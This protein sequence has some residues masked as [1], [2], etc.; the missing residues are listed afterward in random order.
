MNNSM[1]PETDFNPEMQSLADTS[2]A[3][4]FHLQALTG[5]VMQAIRLD[6]NDRR[7]GDALYI[8]N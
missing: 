5:L 2:S 7:Q 6:Q 4:S 1:M 3:D 8:S